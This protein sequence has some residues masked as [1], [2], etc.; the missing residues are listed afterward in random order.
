MSLLRGLSLS[1]L[2]LLC[3]V[4]F[5]AIGLVWDFRRLV[6]YHDPRAVALWVGVGLLFALPFW[7]PPIVARIWPRAMPKTRQFCAAALCLP[8]LSVL[9]Y[10]LTLAFWPLRAP[11]HL[12][13]KGLA[14]M[15]VPYC[16][17][18]A[19]LLWP[20]ASGSAGDSAP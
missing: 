11:H 7:L 1:V 3:F 16:L 2:G 17:G 12:A 5:G 14:M 4:V 6:L 18:L 13:T 19:I 8:P 10:L 20:A 15:F 9:W